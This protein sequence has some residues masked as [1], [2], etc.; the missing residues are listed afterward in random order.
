MAA[1]RRKRRIREVEERMD[2]CQWVKNVRHCLL[3]ED[4]RTCGIIKDLSS[5]MAE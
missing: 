4:F 3:C 1:H 2:G 5:A